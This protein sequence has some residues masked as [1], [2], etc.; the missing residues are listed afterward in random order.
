MKI[1]DY[2]KERIRFYLEDYLIYQRQILR[3][4]MKQAESKEHENCEMLVNCSKQR[5]QN[6]KELLTKLE[7]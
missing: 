6:V 1:T 2:N 4:R 3:K 7:D 5:T